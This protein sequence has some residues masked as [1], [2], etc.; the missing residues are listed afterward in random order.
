M[1]EAKSLLEQT[2]LVCQGR[3]F[4]QS[5]LACLRDYVKNDLRRIDVPPAELLSSRP[6]EDPLESI[7]CARLTH[8]AILHSLLPAACLLLHSSASSPLTYYF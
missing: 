2:T 4:Y 7:M 8:H 1:S 3:P 5:A 6:M